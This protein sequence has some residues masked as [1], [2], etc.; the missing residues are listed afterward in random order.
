MVP[1]TI[2]YWIWTA[3]F[4]I[5]KGHFNSHVCV[6]SNWAGALQTLC[7]VYK[8][9]P[10]TW[11]RLTMMGWTVFGFTL[12]WS[13]FVWLKTLVF[14]T[15]QV[16]GHLRKPQNNSISNTQYKRL[17][18]QIL[19]FMDLNWL[20][21]RQERNQVFPGFHSVLWLGDVSRQFWHT[22]PLA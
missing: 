6:L 22:H 7:Y 14:P 21:S 3:K 20:P 18:I 4:L 10:L 12:E 11:R 17:Y 13:S 1:F 19:L 16:M 9:F 5:G 8:P 15:T 2:L